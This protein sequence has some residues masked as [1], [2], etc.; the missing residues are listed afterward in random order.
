MRQL[1][2]KVFFSSLEF[3]T[4]STLFKAFNCLELLQMLCPIHVHARVFCEETDLVE[5]SS[6]LLQWHKRLF[7][8]NKHLERIKLCKYKAL[9]K[10]LLIL[11]CSSASFPSPLYKA[12]C[13]RPHNKSIAEPK[14]LSNARIPVLKPKCI[15]PLLYFT[16]LST[17]GPL[18]KS[19]LY[20]RILKERLLK[21]FDPCA[22]QIHPW[23]AKVL[24]RTWCFTV[25]QSP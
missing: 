18:L 15:S 2:Y 12:G 24:C 3:Q 23:T 17:L 11:R 25:L 1:S 21:P 16:F 8:N 10:H 6:V 7:Q 4:F 19:L 5:G 20:E 14:L 13:P 9:C 22:Q